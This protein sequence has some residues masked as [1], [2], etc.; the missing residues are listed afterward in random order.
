MIQDKINYNNELN[1]FKF[2]EKLAILGLNDRYGL[3]FNYQLG[4]VSVMF[5]DS[6]IV[7]YNR[8]GQ[9]A[10]FQCNNLPSDFYDTAIEFIRDEIHKSLSMPDKSTQPLPR[11]KR[12]FGINE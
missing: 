6:D 11:L 1:L 5:I 9:S 10:Y 7:I 2:K 8:F 3:A 12:F 4:N